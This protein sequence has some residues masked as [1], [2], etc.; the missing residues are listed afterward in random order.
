MKFI[1]TSYMR[2]FEAFLRLDR[3]GYVMT[4]QDIYERYA[5]RAAIMQY[6]GGLTYGRASQ[7][8]FN[9]VAKW[10]KSTGRRFPQLVRDDFRRVIVGD[11]NN[12][13]VDFAE[14]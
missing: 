3:G 2:F 8:V 1:A 11:N 12:A 5:E 4:D 14:R 13:R 9:Q 6:E 7:T 10:C